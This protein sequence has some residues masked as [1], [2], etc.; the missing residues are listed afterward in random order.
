MLLT[1]SA[2]IVATMP[3]LFQSATP[4]QASSSSSAAHGPLTARDSSRALRI[5]RRAQGDFETLRRRLLPFERM[6]DGGD[7]DDAIGRY[8]LRQQFTAPPAESPEVIAAR[9]Y[10]LKT[11][12]SIGAMIP[13]DRWILGQRTRYLIEAGRPLGADSMA[14]TCAARSVAD[15]TTSWCYALIGYT[16]QQLGNYPRADAAFSTA[17]EKM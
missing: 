1:F 4:A 9:T 6:G 13:G 10:L 8:C 2:L 7:C 3:A 15:A 17:L 11:L 16:A 14:I 12:D 5:A